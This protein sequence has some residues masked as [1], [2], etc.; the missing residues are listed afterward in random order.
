MF[1]LGAKTVALVADGKRKEFAVL[2]VD[3]KGNVYTDGSTSRLF[4][5]Y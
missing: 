1:L 3:K 5:M 2:A 4:Q